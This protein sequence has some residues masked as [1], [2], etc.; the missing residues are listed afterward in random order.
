MK[1]DHQLVGKKALAKGWITP[2]QLEECRKNCERDPGD[3][4]SP[5][6]LGVVLVSKGYLTDDQLLFLLER[7]KGRGK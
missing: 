3:R 1:R 4:R 5:R 7:E 6:P 2:Q